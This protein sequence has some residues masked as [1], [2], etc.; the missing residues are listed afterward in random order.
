MRQTNGKSPS[1]QTTGMGP[2]LCGLRDLAWHLG[3]SLLYGT[4][5]DP[6][7]DT[8]D[9]F[10]ASVQWALNFWVINVHHLHG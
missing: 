10:A 6:D 8:F 2:H 9:Q 5:D 7:G 4:R 3:T 1:I